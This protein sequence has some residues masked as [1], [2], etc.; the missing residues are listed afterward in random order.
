VKAVTISNRGEVG[1]GSAIMIPG[2]VVGGEGAKTVLIRG[3][4]PKLADF[5]VEGVLENPTLTVFQGEAPLVTNDDWSDASNATELAAAA[6][7]VGAFALDSGSKDAAVLVVLDPG[8]YTVKV[9]GVGNTIG[10]ALVEIY[11]VQEE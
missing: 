8:R 11:E 2:F 3:V 7:A 5:G 10:V 6:S 4:G 9:S 1:V